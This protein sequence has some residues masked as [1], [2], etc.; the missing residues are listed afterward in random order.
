VT[1]F[2][3]WMDR[4]GAVKSGTLIVGN[5]GGITAGSKWDQ[6]CRCRAGPGEEEESS[7]AETGRVVGVERGDGD[8]EC[9][10][11]MAS[12]LFSNEARGSHLRHGGR[13]SHKANR[14]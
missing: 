9:S 6:R 10:C 8:Q 12:I 5:N 14:I 1:H 11:P 7:P 2:W 3:L 13:L 4:D